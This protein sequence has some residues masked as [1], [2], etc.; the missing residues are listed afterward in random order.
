MYDWLCANHLSLNASKTEFIVFRPPS[1]SINLRITLK[2]HHTK[3]YESRKIKYLGLILDNKL[4]WKFHIIELSK[5]LSRAIGMLY[6]IRKFCTPSTLRSLYFSLFNSH[7]SYGLAVWGNANAADKNKIIV[8]QKR[9]LR[10]ISDKTEDFDKLLYDLKILSIDDQ[11]RVQLSSLMWDYDH[12]MLP[13]SLNVLFRRSNLVHNYSARRASKS[14]LYYSKVR[15][16]KSGIQSFKYQG[17]HSLNNLKKL[18]FY[19]NTK[20]KG[21][22]LKQLKP[23]LISK[24]VK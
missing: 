14:H 2:L 18:S 22:F 5:K 16:R 20:I 4:S 24:Y 3:L 23:Y 6:K 8:L 11:L 7:L 17:I 12:E 13:S 10:A 1:E 19:Q 9:A 21:K 15:T